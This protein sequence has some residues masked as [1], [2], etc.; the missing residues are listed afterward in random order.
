MADPGLAVVCRRGK[1]GADELSCQD[2]VRQ[3]LE[4]AGAVDV[5]AFEN[6]AIPGFCIHEVGGA[7]MG[8]DP[9]QSV[10]NKYNQCHDVP[11]VFVTDGAAFASSACQNPSLTFMALTARAA[12]Y[13]AQRLK[14][15]AFA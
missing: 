7:R 8:A 10:L 15:G 4:A 3:L 13:A 6:E 12:D 1:P 14:E 9:K 2:K 5:E 11:N